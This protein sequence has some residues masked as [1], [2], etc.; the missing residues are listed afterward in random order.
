[1]FKPSPNEYTSSICIGLCPVKLELIIFL[2]KVLLEVKIA[3]E[4]NKHPPPSNKIWKN[5]NQTPLQNV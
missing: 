5:K 3:P 2:R 4:S 1:M